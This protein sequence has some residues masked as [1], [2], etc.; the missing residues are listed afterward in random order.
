L[1][2]Q[3]TDHSTAEI[4]TPSGEIKDSDVKREY[5]N[6]AESLRGFHPSSYSSA[7]RHSYLGPALNRSRQL[8]PAAEK[9]TPS[10]KGVS[11]KRKEDVVAEYYIS[12]ERGPHFDILHLRFGDDPGQNDAVVR[13]AVQELSEL[14]SSGEL[15]GG[16]AVKIAG[17]APPPVAIALGHAVGH[18][19]EVVAVFDA[20]L[21][22]YIVAI[23][24]YCGY[25][26]GDLI[27]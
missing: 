27:D 23:S 20:A 7:A 18:L 3:E 17:P 5:E 14:I 4:V 21:G 12:V 22:R 8:S 2:R 11:Q 10:A 15:T 16:Q 26:P 19:Y 6:P 1:S 13:C 9:E 24:H 25:Y